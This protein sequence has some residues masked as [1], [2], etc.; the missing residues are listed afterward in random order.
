MKKN[1]LMFLSLLAGMIMIGCGSKG[2]DVSGKL[3]GVWQTDWSADLKGDLKEIQV[4]ERLAFINGNESGSHGDFRQIFTGTVEFDDNENEGTVPYLVTVKGDWGVKNGNEVEMRYDVNSMKVQVSQGSLE[5]DFATVGEGFSLKVSA[6]GKKLK[7]KV[8][9][10]VVRQVSSY[11]RDIFHKI[12]E[13]KVGLK[14]VEIDGKMLTCKVNEGMMGRKVTYDKVDIDDSK[15]KAASQPAETAAAPAAAP[16]APAV[17]P[18]APAPAPAPR[19]T[20]AG[21]PDYSWLSSTYV[22]GADLAGRSKSELRIMRNYI[23][24]RHGY[25]FKSPDLQQYFANY[26][27]YTPRYSNVENMLSSVERSNV[28]T[29]KS[30]E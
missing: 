17:A 4:Y 23:Y 11:F 6:D 1:Y 20:T 18:A 7:Q 3:Q 19:V 28:M 21:M 27:W 22:S 14:S 13:D 5:A 16:A 25:K 15:L 8:E 26:S 29:I 24:A 30:Y 12:N 2:E 9:D 10:M